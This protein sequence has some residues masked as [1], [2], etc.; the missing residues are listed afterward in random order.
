MEINLGMLAFEVTRRCNESCLH[1][2]KGKA[3]SIDMTKEIIDKVLKNPNYKI[4]EMKYLAIAGGEPTLVPDI[5]VYLIDTIIEEDI[6]ITSNINFITNGFIYS[7]KIIDSLDRLMKY[8]K[9]K[10]NCKDTRLVFEISNDQFHKRPSKEVLDKYKKL[11]YIDKSFFEQ[12]EIPKE[13]ILNDGRAKENGLGGNRTY[14]NYLSPID[15]KLDRDKLTIKNE[16]IITSNGNVT[17]AVGGPYKDEDEN[18]WGN[19]NEEDFSKIIIDK[20][21]SIV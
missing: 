1:C 11:S 10:E 21:K 14:K 2:C 13:K 20:K 6:S 18:S 5:V 17:S 19:L 8:L 9:T 12:R 7:E 16:L 15:I 4:K 3:E